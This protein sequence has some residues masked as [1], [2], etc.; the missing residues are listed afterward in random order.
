MTD[1]TAPI[2]LTDAQG[3]QLAALLDTLVP[4]S[5][6]GSMP[7]AATLNFAGYLAGQTGDAVA[8]TLAVL[9]RFGAGLADLALDDRVTAVE[10]FASKEPEAFDDLLFRVY[11]CYYQNDIVRRLIGSEAGPPFPRG[12]TIP[13]GDLST[14]D[15]VVK[16]SPGYRQT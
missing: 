15:A 2:A 3:R 11:D 9:D 8:N 16:R 6:D 13:A 14:L 12:N 10:A 1:N 7:S 5:A 4:A